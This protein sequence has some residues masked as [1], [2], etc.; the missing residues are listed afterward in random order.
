M[1]GKRESMLSLKLY[2]DIQNYVDEHY[3]A[4]ELQGDLEEFLIRDQ[5]PLEKATELKR[6]VS[7]VAGRRSGADR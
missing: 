7:C 2:E 4:A 3:L 5:A 1:N 6:D